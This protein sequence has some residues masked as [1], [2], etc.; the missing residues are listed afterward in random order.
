MA[1]VVED[2]R[3]QRRTARHAREH[4][5]RA[6]HREDRAAERLD[7]DLLGRSVGG[8]VGPFH[9]LPREI[10]EL[11]GTPGVVLAGRHEAP[12]RVDD[13]GGENVRGGVDEPPGDHHGQ[14]SR[15]PLARISW[16]VTVCV[17]LLAALLLLLNGYSGYAGVLVAVGAAAAVNAV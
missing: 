9:E 17:C 4:V 16:I 10:R 6:A 11:A 8:G 15:V 2:E 3:G 5:A 1:Q 7:L 12:R 14:N 13:D